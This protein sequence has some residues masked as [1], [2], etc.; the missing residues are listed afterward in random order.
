MGS[1]ALTMPLLAILTHFYWMAVGLQSHVIVPEILELL[2]IDSPSES[3]AQRLYEHLGAHHERTIPLYLNHLR[4]TRNSNDISQIM[5]TISNMNKYGI[6]RYN[7]LFIPFAVRGV[8]IETQRAYSILFI[9]QYG[10]TN[11][12]RAISALLDDSKIEVGTVRQ[13]LTCL[14]LIGGR[15][16]VPTLRRFVSTALAKEPKSGWTIEVEPVIKAI[17]LRL[18]A[19]DKGIVTTP[20]KFAPPPWRSE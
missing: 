15:D 1:I 12:S 20:Y 10:T 2:E 9:R 8:S 19:H 11:E 7:H 4:D 17:E 14:H 18:E 3:T 13:V 5:L 16:D 6:V